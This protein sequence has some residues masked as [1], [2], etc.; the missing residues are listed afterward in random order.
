MARNLCI[1]GS[2]SINKNVQFCSFIYKF[3]TS[4][5]L[6]IGLVRFLRNIKNM[7]ISHFFI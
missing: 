2:N 6:F 5:I 1:A 3:I 7:G 4:D